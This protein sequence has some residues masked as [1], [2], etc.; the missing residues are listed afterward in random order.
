MKSIYRRR[1]K[2]K[3][4]I[5]DIL[6]GVRT[7]LFY[8][9]LLGMVAAGVWFLCVLHNLTFAWAAVSIFLIALALII[10]G[11]CALCLAGGAERE[12][13]NKY[14]LIRDI[15]GRLWKES[16]YIKPEDIAENPLDCMNCVI[17]ECDLEKV[18]LEVERDES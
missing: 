6:R 3:T 16:I 10:T 2:M 1:R 12:A 5:L 8:L 4:V 17:R 14:S 7:G 13:V 18:L 11:L 9:M 15:R